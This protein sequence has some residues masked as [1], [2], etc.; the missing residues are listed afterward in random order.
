MSKDELWDLD[1]MDTYLIMLTVV[2]VLFFGLSMY[3]AVQPSRRSTA[4]KSKTDDEIDSDP[5]NLSTCV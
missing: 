5:N 2:S 3:C 4:D 1:P